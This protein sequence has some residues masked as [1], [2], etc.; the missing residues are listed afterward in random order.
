M[1][2]ATEVAAAGLSQKRFGNW[3]MMPLLSMFAICR[4]SFSTAP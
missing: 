1:A 3:L 4:I 2:A